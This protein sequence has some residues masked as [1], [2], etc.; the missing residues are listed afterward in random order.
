MLQ[1]SQ[2]DLPPLFVEIRDDIPA[3][4]AAVA[5]LVLEH[6]AAIAAAGDEAALVL[7]AGDTDAAQAGV[8]ILTYVGIQPAG[9]GFALPSPDDRPSFKEALAPW[10]DRGA[11]FERLNALFGDAALLPM[12]S[13]LLDDLEAFNAAST[14]DRFEMHRLGGF[15]GTLGFRRLAYCAERL[16]QGALSYLPAM[17]REAVWARA[18]VRGYLRNSLDPTTL[19]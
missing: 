4:R 2:T 12:T 15:A 3:R 17:R 19:V 5:A 18:I 8:P 16:S 14:I 11:A 6:R 7:S 1:S 13:R 9:I 10:L